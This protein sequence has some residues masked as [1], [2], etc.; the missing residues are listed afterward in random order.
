MIHVPS[1]FF[2][3]LPNQAYA[4]VNRSYREAYARKKEEQ[5]RSRLRG[6]GVMTRAFDGT[7]GERGGTGGH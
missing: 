7:W 1:H 5:G 3:K 2:P 4:R 6:R